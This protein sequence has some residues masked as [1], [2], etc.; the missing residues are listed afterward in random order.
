MQSLR[1][2]KR[3]I[4][5][6]L[7]L[8]EN[9]S[10]EACMR[11]FVLGL[12]LFLACPYSTHSFAQTRG[13]G[14]KLYYLDDS[15]ERYYYDKGS[16]ESV[17]KGTVIVW[18]KIT[19]NSSGEEVDKSTVHLRLNCR[20]KT[21]DVLADGERD[22]PDKENQGPAGDRRGNPQ[23]GDLNVRA[24]SKLSALFENVCPF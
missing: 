18:Q 4:Y 10:R 15:G 2:S 22:R 23:K 6:I 5:D 3:A 13:E 19:E 9:G 20:Q 16:V 1:Q 7:S 8:F 24:D 14:W 21:F 12:A 11:Y 17:Q